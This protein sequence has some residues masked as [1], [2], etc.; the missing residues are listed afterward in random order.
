[1]RIVAKPFGLGDGQKLFSIGGRD[2]MR[3]GDSSPTVLQTPVAQPDT[4]CQIEFRLLQITKFDSKQ[5]GFGN[6]NGR[7]SWGLTEIGKD[8]KL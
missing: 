5:L 4:S 6:R 8:E 2:R 3:T 7:S 1:M